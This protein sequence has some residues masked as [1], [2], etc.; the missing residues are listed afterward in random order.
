[1]GFLK[2]FEEK[3][4]KEKDFNSL[5]IDIANAEIEKD[6]CRVILRLALEEMNDAKTEY[7]N[8]KQVLKYLKELLTDTHEKKMR[9][10]AE[11]IL[12]RSGH[13]GLEDGAPPV[14]S[15]TNDL[16]ACNRAYINQKDDCEFRR[17]YYMSLKEGVRQARIDYNNAAEDCET[18]ILYLINFAKN[19]DEPETENCNE[20]EK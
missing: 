6:K 2:V 8:Y 20:N 12:W 5:A 15:Y 11:Y 16:I 14:E 7:K 18:A 10:I 3:E 17:S 13:T 4:V 19:M 9:F 1:M